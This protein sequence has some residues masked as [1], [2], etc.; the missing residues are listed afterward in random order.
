MSKQ[1]PGDL[2]RGQRCELLYVELADGREIELQFTDLG[3]V[4]RCG[5]SG[6]SSVLGCA[7]FC[8]VAIVLC[9]A[10]LIAVL[11]GETRAARN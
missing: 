5:K 2:H 1:L 3:V 4:G 7:V 9:V 6:V 10:V 11:Y 8:I